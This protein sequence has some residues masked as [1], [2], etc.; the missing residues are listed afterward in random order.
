MAT[1]LRT[2]GFLSCEGIPRAGG[3]G[4]RFFLGHGCHDVEGNLSARPTL[5]LL[6]SQKDPISQAQEG[7]FDEA[8]QEGGPQ[9][10]APHAQQQ[11]GPTSLG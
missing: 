2:P 8:V 6:P 10:R 11:H 9:Q 4:R 3:N 1:Q 7:L 5:G